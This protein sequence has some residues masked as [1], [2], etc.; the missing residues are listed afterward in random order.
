MKNKNPERHRSITVAA[1]L[2]WL[3]LNTAACVALDQ[4][5]TPE[6]RGIRQADAL[7]SLAGV[8]LASLPGTP[9]SPGELLLALYS[10]GTCLF[11]EKRFGK[12]SAAVMTG[13][14]LMGHHD[15]RM[16]LR[17]KNNNG[18]QRV[19]TLTHLKPDFKLAGSEY[20]TE[21]LVLTRQYPANH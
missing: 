11:V 9:A 17:L 16:T 21:G 6:E 18:A 8:Y 3:T 13:R 20:G 2:V 19:L 1:F 5:R 7:Q 14:W 15:Q 12:T 10:D 4:S